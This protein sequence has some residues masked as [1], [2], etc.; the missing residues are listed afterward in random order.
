MNR[1]RRRATFRS[2]SKKWRS[3]KSE[4]RTIKRQEMKDPR[5]LRGFILLLALISGCAN[6]HPQS[7]VTTKPVSFGQAQPDEKLNRLFERTSG[8]IGADGAFSVSLSDDRSLW[9]FSDTW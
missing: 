2:F 1:G 3:R 6:E 8:W 9:L 7:T 4:R 5:T